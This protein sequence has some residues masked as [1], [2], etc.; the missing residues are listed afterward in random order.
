MIDG[1]RC[2]AL[3]KQRQLGLGEPLVVTQTTGSTNDDALAAARSGAPHGATFVAEQ[4][5]RGRGRRG[6]RWLSRAGDG[7][8]F[9]VLLR[10]ALDVER[11][12]A[13]ALAVGLAI[14][15]VVAQRVDD[16]VL[17]KWPNDVVVRGK[18]LAGI[19]CES[20]VDGRAL[21]AIVVGV[22]LNVEL[23]DPDPEIVESATSLSLLGASELAHEA[24]LVDLLAAIEQRVT[25]Y[26]S[27]GLA[28]MLETLTRYDALDGRKL[29]V[30][31]I[32]GTGSGIAPDGAL[33]VRGFDGQRHE[34][35]S[36]TVE[37]LD[38]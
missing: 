3:A 9:S 33:V 23:G 8:L 18:K 13:L 28:P 20:Q 2:R 10:P 12:S 5:T 30:G 16:P 19:L 27:A 4:Q 25:E 38:R 6:N 31:E 24:L 7:L 15:D 11:A 32:E 26:A 1:A 36:G 14:R 34:I 35:R 17:V 29:R 37:L 22:G 21:S